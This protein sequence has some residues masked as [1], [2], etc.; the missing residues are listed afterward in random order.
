MIGACTVS[1]LYNF[2]N[3]DCIK[4]WHAK[5]RSFKRTL[6]PLSAVQLNCGYFIE[7]LQ[8]FVVDG[9]AATPCNHRYRYL[10]IY[11]SIIASE[12]YAV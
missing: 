7:W 9:N 8:F 5:K 2:I 3:V 1:L 12:S 6:L 11:L 10:N 4:I